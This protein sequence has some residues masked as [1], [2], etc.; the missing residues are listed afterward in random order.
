MSVSAT[1]SRIRFA[2]AVAIVRST[3]NTRVRFRDM[4]YG[5]ALSRVVSV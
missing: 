2:A 5:Q 1:L 3:S 4:Q